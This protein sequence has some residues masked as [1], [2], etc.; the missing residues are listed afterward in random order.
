MRRRVVLG[1]LLAAATFWGCGGAQERSAAPAVSAD[2]ATGLEAFAQRDWPKAYAGLLPGAEQGNAEAQFKVGFM[3]L[4]GL[5]MPADHAEADLW[6]R[7]AAE[8]GYGEA[9][10]T[11]ALNYRRGLGVPRDIVKAL[12]WSTLAA[13]QGYAAA[14][15][16]RDD[17]LSQMTEEQIA[18]ARRLASEWSAAH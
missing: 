2:L 5:G 10:H 8:Q 12:M 14:K 11:L 9:Q 13:E 1:T 4:Y 7:R 15:D 3:Y 16:V 17:S 18:E 6:I